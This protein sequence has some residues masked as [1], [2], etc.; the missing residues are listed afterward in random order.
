MNPFLF[1]KIVRGEY[2]ADRKEEMKSIENELLSGQ[3]LVLI[4]PRRYGKTS[5]VINALEEAD[6]HYL[7]IDMELVTGEDDFANLLIRKA[8]SL[9]RFEKFKDHLKILRVQPDFRYNPE[10]G[11]FSITLGP[12]KKDIPVYLEDALNFPE[13]VATSQ[14]RRLVIIFDEFQEVRRISP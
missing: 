9:S 5:L 1:G 13:M 2:F 6:T 11:E 12:E 14:K 4:S 7:Y 3:N 10:S 8:L